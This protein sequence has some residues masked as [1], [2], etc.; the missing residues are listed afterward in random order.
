MTGAVIV[1]G[2][3]DSAESIRRRIIAAY[4]GEYKTIRIKSGGMRMQPAHTR[5]IRDMVRSSMIGTEIVES[6][7]ESMLIQILTRLPELSFETALKRM[8][9]M[10]SNMH[11]EALESLSACD[12][13]HSEEVIRMDDKTDRFGLYMRRNLVTAVGNTDALLD[14][15]LQRPSDCLGYREVAGRIERIADHA[16]LIAKRV[17]F[18]DGRIE[19]KLM[20]KILA[21]SEGSPSVFGRSVEALI[22]RDLASPKGSP[23]RQKM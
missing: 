8:H 12:A 1:S 10:A 19:P 2:Q 3:N 7:S 4:L 6:S 21:I 13:G 18:L 14:M 17:K 5:A 23:T 22:K 11:R 16:G 15:G 20:K 9:L